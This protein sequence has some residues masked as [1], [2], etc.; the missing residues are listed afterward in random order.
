MGRFLRFLSVGTPWA[1]PWGPPWGPPMGGGMG[2]AR[3]PPWGGPGPQGGV[4]DFF[5]TSKKGVGVR[6]SGGISGSIFAFWQFFQ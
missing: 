6:A 4:N 5:L 1:P 3:P 2:G